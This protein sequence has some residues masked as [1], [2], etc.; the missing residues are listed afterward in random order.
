MTKV[1][2]TKPQ[3]L[4]TNIGKKYKAQ[5][6]MQSTTTESYGLQNPECRKHYKTKN[7]VPWTKKICCKENMKKEN[8][9]IKQPEEWGRWS[10]W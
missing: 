4:I 10:S 6:N 5:K 1:N 8:Q 9:K 2:S 7:L 3:D